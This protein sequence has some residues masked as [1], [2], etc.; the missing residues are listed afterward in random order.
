MSYVHISNSLF[1]CFIQSPLIQ[2][3]IVQIFFYGKAAPGSLSILHSYEPC[4]LTVIKKTNFSPLRNYQFSVVPY[5]K[6]E[7]QVNLLFYIETVQVH[8]VVTLMSSNVQLPH[9]MKK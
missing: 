4:Y 1:F 6:I 3:C 2:N 5:S 9:W 7:S 8:I